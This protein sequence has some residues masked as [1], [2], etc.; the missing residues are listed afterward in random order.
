MRSS[1]GGNG[2][3]KGLILHNRCEF[4][5]NYY[6]FVSLY[7]AISDL[8]YTISSC[9]IAYITTLNELPFPL[10]LCLDCM[11]FVIPNA[12]CPVK[13]GAVFSEIH[14]FQNYFLLFPY[15]VYI[16]NFARTEVCTVVCG[17]DPCKSHVPISNRFR[18]P[19]VKRMRCTRIWTPFSRQRASYLGLRSAIYV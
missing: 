5:H 15:T 2:E 1:D 13:I 8:P 14:E 19:K 16:V 17:T 18:R 7:V 6:T 11:I 3:T 10:I 9:R 4:L 12:G